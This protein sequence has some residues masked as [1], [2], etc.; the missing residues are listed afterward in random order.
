MKH[1]VKYRVEIDYYAQE[2][3]DKVCQTS[4]PFYTLEEAFREY[5]A[6]V[7]N[8]R[9]ID[10]PGRPVRAWLWKYKYKK[11]NGEWLLDPVTLAKNY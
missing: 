2:Y 7:D 8:A 1:K 6:A 4:A 5:I 11:G 10:D 3:P 9:C